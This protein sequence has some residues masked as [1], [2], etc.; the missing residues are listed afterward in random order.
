[1]RYSQL[2]E[3]VALQPGIQLIARRT[4]HAS[5][6]YLLDHFPRFP[7]MPGVM[8]LEAL[9][10]AAMWMVRTGEDFASPHV[11]LVEAKSVKF[12]DFLCPGETLEI[13]ADKFKEDGPLVTVKAQATKGDKVTVSARLILERSGSEAS[14]HNNDDDTRRFVREQFFNMFGDQPAVI[15]AMTQSTL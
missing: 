6:D 9:Y 2:D 5:E 13:K 8:M 1:M 10:Q 11:F 3:I 7:V 4:L 15:Q 14:P 12:G